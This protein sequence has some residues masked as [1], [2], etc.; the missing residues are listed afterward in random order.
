MKTVTFKWLKASSY[1]SYFYSDVDTTAGEYVLASEAEA[2]IVLKA[3]SYDANSEG[4]QQDIAALKE[5]EQFLM[6][7]LEKLRR[8]SIRALRWI[9]QHDDLYGDL[10]QSIAN[11][12][13]ALAQVNGG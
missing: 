7:A 3:K 6:K 11:L 2:E 4:W 8:K 5:R 1:H 12:D 13:A 10:N 9:P